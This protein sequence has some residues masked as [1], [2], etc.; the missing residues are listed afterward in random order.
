MR[1]SVGV[2]AQGERALTHAEVVELA[3]VVAAY[4]G[5]ASGIGTARFGAQLL[6][7]APTREEA[8]ERGRALFSLAVA[9]AGLPAAPIV[10]VD[11]VTEDDELT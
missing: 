4:R 5:I 9:R 11:A 2:A 8:I 1:W 6:V 7:E 10:Q 3:D